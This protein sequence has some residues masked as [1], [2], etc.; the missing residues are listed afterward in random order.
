LQVYYSRQRIVAW[1]F[2]HFCLSANF[3]V[4]E[5]FSRRI[6]CRRIGQSP[7]HPR[8]D[9]V[10][11]Y[12]EARTDSRDKLHHEYSWHHLEL[13]ISYTSYYSSALQP[14]M[15]STINHT[16]PVQNSG[17]H[18]QGSVDFRSAVHRRTPTTPSDDVV[19]AVHR[20]S[21]SLC[22]VDTHWDSQASVLCGGTERLELTIE[23]HS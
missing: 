13:S 19:S 8:T 12:T 16:H 6:D 4:R 23:W 2:I 18:A 11:E 9:I 22:A 17:H 14:C 21:A 3:R 20:C 10:V 7:T 5:S 1:Q 15:L